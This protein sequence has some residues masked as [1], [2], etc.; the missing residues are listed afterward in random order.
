MSVV[1]SC[2]YANQ[3][4]CF[5]CLLISSLH[6]EKSSCLIAVGT[7]FVRNVFEVVQKIR[8]TCYSRLCHEFLN[9]IKQYCFKQ[10][11]KRYCGSSYNFFVVHRVLK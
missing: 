8:S 3:F 4:V 5:S 2:R 6:A 9:L 1:G 10:Y 11:L 7:R